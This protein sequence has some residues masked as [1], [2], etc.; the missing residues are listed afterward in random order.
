MGKS[1]NLP[2]FGVRQ[3]QNVHVHLLEMR[4]S[5]AKVTICLFFGLGKYKMCVHSLDLTDLEQNVPI[6]MVCVL[7]KYKTSVSIY[8]LSNIYLLLHKIHP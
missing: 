3:V 6:S 7:G 5:W 1:D 8:L 4:E 2:V